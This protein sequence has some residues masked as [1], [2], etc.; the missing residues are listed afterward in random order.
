MK[1][2]L[3]ICRKAVFDSKRG[4][5]RPG[6]PFSA[7]ES[8]RPTDS[9]NASA[10]LKPLLDALQDARIIKTDRA[11]HCRMETVEFEYVDVH[12]LE[13]VWVEVTE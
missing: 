10:A 12:S 3:R 1:R 11:S 5:L 7:L 13:G 2:T 8:Y 6:V 9:D 4:E